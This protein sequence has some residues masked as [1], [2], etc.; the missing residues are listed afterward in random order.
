MDDAFLHSTTLVGISSFLAFSG[1]DRKNDVTQSVC[2]PVVLLGFRRPEF[3]SQV[4]EQIRRARPAKLFLVMDGPTPGNAEESQLVSQTREIAERVDWPCE[5]T[6]I[7]SPVNMGLKRRV[8]T[9]LT[10][11][12]SLVDRAII[13]EDD[14]VPSPDFFRLCTELLERYR[15]NPEVGIISGA[16]RLRGRAFSSDSYVFSRD[17][18]IWGWATWARTWN[19]FVESGDLS[20]TWNEPHISLVAKRFPTNARRRA[21]AG[22]LRA[23][24]VL[25]SWALPFAIHCLSRG[26]SNPVSSVNLVRN[27]GFGATSTHTRFES[28]VKDVPVESLTWPL[29]HPSSTQPMDEFDVLESKSDRREFWRYPLLHPVDTTRRALRYIR[30]VLNRKKDETQRGEA[31]R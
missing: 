13:L 12:F 27:I 19:P 8:S 23:G 26:Y 29:R 21:I 17:V 10:E 20:K 28:Y 6:T 4:F 7:Y 14:C 9:G 15:D 18:R 22:M 31:K 16:S 24:A 2:A 5:V 11:V 30:L 25:D 1:W 3:T